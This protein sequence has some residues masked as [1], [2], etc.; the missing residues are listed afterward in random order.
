MGIIPL[1]I[2][3]IFTVI[4]FLRSYPQINP[5]L[6]MM[7]VGMILFTGGLLILIFAWDE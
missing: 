7:G 4:T 5:D 2:G 3:I 1:F 6:V